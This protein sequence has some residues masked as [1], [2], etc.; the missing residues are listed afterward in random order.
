MTCYSIIHRQIVDTKLT[1]ICIKL[2][3]KRPFVKNKMNSAIINQDITLHVSNLLIIKSVFSDIS[4]ENFEAQ[5]PRHIHFEHVIIVVLRFDFT[6]LRIGA[7]QNNEGFAMTT[8]VIAI[9]M[10]TKSALT[11]SHSSD[12]EYR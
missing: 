5:L 2:A 1:Q 12:S 6:N 8:A 10:T 9:Q 11:L 3:H 4:I 7:L